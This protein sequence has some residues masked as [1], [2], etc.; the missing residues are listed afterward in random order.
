MHECGSEIGDGVGGVRGHGIGQVV[1]WDGED[2]AKGFLVWAG[3]L[4]E[5][6]GVGE[7]G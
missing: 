5:F 2:F 1:A 4:E 3:G 7:F 6:R